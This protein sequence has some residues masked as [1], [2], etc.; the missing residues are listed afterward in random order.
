M[1]ALLAE[2]R[3]SVRLATPI[4]LAQ[5]AMMG[6][7][8]ADTIMAG[9]LSAA[10]LAAV[11]SGASYWM[12]LGLL[13][14]GLANG[15]SPIVAHQRGAGEASDHIGR[16]LQ[17]CL[18]VAVLVG[19]LLLVV[20]RVT[21][22]P[23][24]QRL[25]LSPA[26]TEAATGYLRAVALGSP[27]F[28]VLLVLRFGADGMGETRPFLWVGIAGLIVNVLLNYVL[29]WG[30]WGAP[31]LGAL[32]CGYATA[33]ADTTMMVL[34]ALAY[35]GNVR[36]R[37]LNLFAAWVAPRWSTIRDWLIVGLPIAAM[38]TFEAGFFGATSLVMARFGDIPAAAHH[39]A[40]NYSAVCFMVPLGIAF[41]ATVRVGH[42]MG[43]GDPEAAQRASWTGVGLSLLFACLS[44]TLMLLAPDV[45]VRLYTDSEQVAP[46]AV[47]LLFW[48]ALFQLF[49]CLQASAAGALR[50]YKD[51]SWPMVITLVAYWAVGM[52]LGTVLA[53]RFEFGPNALW[54]GIIAGLGSAGVLLAWRLA[55]RARRYKQMS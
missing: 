30:N 15:L 21:A 26:G 11:A 55:H 48:A 10:D 44:A 36:L 45:I 41:A 42:A 1:A 53:F 22:A 18:W 16:Y 38:L 39:V 43:R 19:L 13:V 33:I 7:R 8:V 5:L 52:P 17:Q 28:A 49:D 29:M 23:L 24:M 3:A 31:R 6:S 40:I 47:R 12:I 20:M 4:V 50:G 37:A 25:G 32:G 14:I 51:T 9:R 27:A 34:F 54:W 46:L 35:R 2:I